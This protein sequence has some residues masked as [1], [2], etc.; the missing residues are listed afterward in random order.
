MEEQ[1][2]WLP[3]QEAAVRYELDYFQLHK[4][5]RSGHIR[6]RKVAGRIEI[7]ETS[8]AGFL[9]PAGTV[10]LEALVEFMM[11]TAT[12]AKPD[13]LGVLEGFFNAVEY[14][15]LDGKF[16]CTPIAVFR[17]TVLVGMATASAKARLDCA[18]G[19]LLGSW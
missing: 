18:A 6:G 1:E 10:D 16:V 13:V 14:M 9:P 12:V 7:A 8:L 2:I 5:Y 15:L 19:E 3:I 11:Q 4:W 17:P